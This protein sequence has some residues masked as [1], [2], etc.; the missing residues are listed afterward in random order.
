MKEINIL[1]LSAGRR[2]EL[3]ECFKNAAIKEH[4]KSR[5]IAVDISNMAPAIYFADKNYIIPPIG[6]NGY[7]ETIVNLCNRENIK[8]VVP[9]IDSELL[10]L[11]KNKKRIENAT[12]AKVLISDYNI[13]EICRNKIKTYNFFKENGF[14]VP[15]MIAENDLNIN[16]ITFPLFIK[17]FNGSSSINTFKVNNREQL[18]FFK[19]Y[20]E[21]PIIQEFVNGIEYTVDVF[22]DFNGQVITIVP[23]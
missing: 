20:I 6:E 22:C 9:T 16:N 2:V 8:L 21:N 17:P 15:K 1:L 12:N 18:E 10:I 11:S 3:I 4:V 14:G 7:I 23:R 5:I 13:I 19:G